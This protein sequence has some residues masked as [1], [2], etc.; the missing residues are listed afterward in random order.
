MT[1]DS[2]ARRLYILII[3]SL[4]LHLAVGIFIGIKY[5]PKVIS[6]I[7]LTLHEVAAI[8]GRSAPQPHIPPKNMPEQIATQSSIAISDV[9]QLDRS[10][11]QISRENIKPT[12]VN[13]SPLPAIDAVDISAISDSA[14]SFDTRN[15]YFDMVR[16]H[17]ERVKKY[18]IEAKK[19]N[20]EGYVT[21]QFFIT[22]EGHAS[23]VTVSKSAGSEILDQAAINAVLT[24]SPFPAPPADL[25][26]DILKVEISLLFELT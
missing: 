22:K 1:T 14:V 20:R 13:I 25:F 3:I 16:I 26:K 8:T 11:L 15:T 7:E 18:P 5:R 19:S 24:A 9:P 21:V 6:F 4:T 23:S 12:I 2:P 10:D 17:I